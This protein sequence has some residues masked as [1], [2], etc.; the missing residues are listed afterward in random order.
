MVLMNG[1]RQIHRIQLAILEG[2]DHDLHRP[3]Q[4]VQV[5][6]VAQVG[7]MGN[8][9]GTKALHEAQSLVADAGDANVLDPPVSH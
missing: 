2:V 1:Y 6:R 5:R 3:D 8:D 7:H 4:L 9:I